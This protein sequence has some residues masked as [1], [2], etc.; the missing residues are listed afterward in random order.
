MWFHIYLPHTHSSQQKNYFPSY[1]NSLKIPKGQSEIVYRRTEHNCQKKKVQKDKQRSTQH[2]YKAKDRITRT[3]L[4]TE[5]ELRCSG[6]ISTS[7]S[8][9]GIRRVNLVTNPVISRE[10]GKDREVFMTS[11]TY[12]GHL[13]HRYSIAVNQVMLAT[14]KFS[15]WWLQLYQK[16]SMVQLLPCIKVS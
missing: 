15:K 4:K 10:W 14:V 5:G 11:G 9:S 13:W 16:E 12:R 3:P 1:K 2:T 6:R 7:C 8:T